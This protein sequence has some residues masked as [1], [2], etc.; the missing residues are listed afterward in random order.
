M[1]A[2]AVVAV[3]VPPGPQ[4]KEASWHV[5]AIADAQTLPAWYAGS[6]ATSDIVCV[7]AGLRL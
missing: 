7:C 6:R 2:A 3:A 4:L 5:R 1:V